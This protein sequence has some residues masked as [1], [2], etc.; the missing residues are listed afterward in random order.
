MFC[1]IILPEFLIMCHFS[2]SMHQCGETILPS[3]QFAKAH[4]LST[5]KDMRLARI[6]RLIR[7][8]CSQLAFIIV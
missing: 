2:V 5:N 1:V 8:F 7:T 3:M 4:P 6:A